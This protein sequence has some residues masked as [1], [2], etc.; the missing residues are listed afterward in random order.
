MSENKEAVYDVMLMRLSSGEELICKAK[1]LDG[2]VYQ[3]VKP[4][5]LKTFPDK[6][7]G[8]S[9]SFVPIM[10]S[11]EGDAWLVM[12]NHIQAVAVP[13]ESLLDNYLVTI[14]DKPA[15]IKPNTDIIV[16]K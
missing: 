11:A 16:P 15:I 2:K 5:A 10:L 1:E 12:A 6:N 14:G 4:I 7:G 9:M 3:V 8:V 13:N